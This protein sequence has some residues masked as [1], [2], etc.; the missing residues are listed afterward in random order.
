MVWSRR[1]KMGFGVGWFR[2]QCK[3]KEAG[4]FLW[5]W[6]QHACLLADRTEFESYQRT[7]FPI[8]IAR[9][10]QKYETLAV[11]LK[12]LGPLNV[13][14]PCQISSWKISSFVL[15]MVFKWA[16]PGLSIFIF[17]FSTQ[18][19]ANK[20]FKKIAFEPRTFDVRSNCSANWAS[21]TAPDANLV[22]LSIASRSVWNH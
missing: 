4:P 18:L 16:F 10:G 1:S 15:F 19:T 21:T 3:I 12:D 8:L 14:A 22:N 9:N 11:W 6:S 2:E 20:H 13:I 5:T 7:V 17:V